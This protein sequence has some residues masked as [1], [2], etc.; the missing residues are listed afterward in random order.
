M[1]EALLM[2]FLCQGLAFVSSNESLC[3]SFVAFHRLCSVN[4]RPLFKNGS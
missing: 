2:E 1:A 4:M 3:S